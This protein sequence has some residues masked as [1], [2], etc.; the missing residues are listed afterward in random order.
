MGEC[1]SRKVHE[2]GAK[3]LVAALTV[4]PPSCECQPRNVGGREAQSLAR[5]ALGGHPR[6]GSDEVV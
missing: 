5:H 4:H 3:T 2:D 1:A 6:V